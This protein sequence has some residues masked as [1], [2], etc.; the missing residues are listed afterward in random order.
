MAPV[1]VDSSGRYY[2]VVDMRADWNGDRRSLI[3]AG[4]P[5]VLIERGEYRAVRRP[6]PADAVKAQQL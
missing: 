5:P 2:G 6:V 3:L 4:R 1:N